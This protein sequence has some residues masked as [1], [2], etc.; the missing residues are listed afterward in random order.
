MKNTKLAVAVGAGYLLGRMHKAR[1]ALGLAALAAGK[2]LSTSGGGLLEGL[3][4]SSPQLRELAGTVRGDL[5]DAGRKA[6]VSAAGRKIDALTERLETG[7]SAIRGDD[8]DGGRKERAAS[9]EPE[10]D[11]ELDDDKGAR[12]SARRSRT[13]SKTS[14]ARSRTRTSAK[15]TARSRSGAAAKGSASRTTRKQAS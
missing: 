4:D 15:S 13:E 11:E 12:T 1:W 5:A 9:E 2:R 7:T 8:G 10:E 6:V 3:M 14:S